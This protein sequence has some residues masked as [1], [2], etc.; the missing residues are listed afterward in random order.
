VLGIA[1]LVHLIGAT[2][3]TGGHLVL[4]LAILPKALVEKDVSRLLEF[5]SR[6]ELLGIPAL[7]L[8]VASGLW[9][10]YRLLPDLTAWLDWSNPLARL[11]CAKLALLLATAALGLDARLRIIPRLNPD[12]LGVL[13][14][15]IIPVTLLS[16]LFLVI[17]LAFRVGWFT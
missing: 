6:F 3:W 7:L 14:W 17:G 13:A 2:I 16:V 15:H 9:L 1:L 12:R 11:L 5:E 8:Q 10:G 4:A